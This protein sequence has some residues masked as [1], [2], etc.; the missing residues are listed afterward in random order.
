MSVEENK[1]LI[2]RGFWEVWNQRKLDVINE[3]FA[4][5]YVGHITGSP[6]IN[7]PNGYK[8]LITMYINA[9]PDH[10]FKIEDQFGEGDKVVTRWTATSTHKGELMGIPPTGKQSTVTGITINRISDN[11]VVE[12]WSNWDSLSMWQQLGVIPPPGQSEE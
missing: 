7:G 4:K 6:D 8:Q 10:Q 5:D 12:E 3:T 2:R 11:K 1:A 9:F